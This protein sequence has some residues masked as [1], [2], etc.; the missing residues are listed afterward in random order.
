MDCRTRTREKNCITKF[1]PA[2]PRTVAIYIQKSQIFNTRKVHQLG[3]VDACCRSP[4]I[5]IPCVLSPEAPLGA[6]YKLASRRARGI[7]RAVGRA[8]PQLQAA[9]AVAPTAAPAAAAAEA[10][11]QVRPTI[12]P[13]PLLLCRERPRRLLRHRRSGPHQNGV[14]GAGGATVTTRPPVSPA[15]D[16]A[17]AP[18]RLCAPPPHP[19]LLPPDL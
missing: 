2:A 9:P 10:S 1:E 7:T 14:T 5:K 4:R 19:S 3:L 8:A 11:Q 15:V 13:D 16:T 17:I 18:C 6:S 12:P